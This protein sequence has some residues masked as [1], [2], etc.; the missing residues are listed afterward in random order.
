M[1]LTLS[2]PRMRVLTPPLRRQP[3]S[4]HTIA[5]LVCWLDFADAKTITL[6]TGISQIRDKSGFNRHA[7]Q[8][9]AARQPAWNSAQINCR[10]VA[11]FD[12]NNKCI[13]FSINNLGK[14]TL[15]PITP[16]A[17]CYFLIARITSGTNGTLIA[18]NTGSTNI[19][20]RLYYDGANGSP[21]RA[22]FRGQVTT[23]ETDARGA[24]AITHF[25]QFDESPTKS[26]LNGGNLLDHS[27]G[28]SAIQDVPIIIG[29]RWDNS[30]SDTIG[31]PVTAD[32]AEVLF[33]GRALTTPERQFV[34]GYLAWKWGTVNALPSTHPYKS[35]PLYL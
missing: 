6:G 20:H 5:G 22:Q 3:F 35:I 27:V 21:P 28:T 7:S 17:W 33:F 32:I 30:A 8:P 16:D 31:F 23:L 12:G 4:R 26:S 14:C 11:S 29:A 18:K 34:E 13:Y 24:T 9:T 2:P 10:S 25:I 15:N 19:N 1:T